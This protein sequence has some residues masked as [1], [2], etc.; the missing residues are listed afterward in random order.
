MAGDYAISMDGKRIAT[1]QYFVGNPPKRRW[2]AFISG[3][4]RECFNTMREAQAWAVEMH[5]K[6]LAADQTQG[7]R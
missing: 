4:R 6:D 7:R 2:V 3:E 5:K 1:V